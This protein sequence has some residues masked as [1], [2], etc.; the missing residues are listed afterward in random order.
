[1]TAITGNTIYIS[2]E[3]SVKGLYFVLTCHAVYM[4]LNESSDAFIFAA[5]PI[6]DTAVS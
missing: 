2:I 1:M 3:I 5:A 4:G 6:C